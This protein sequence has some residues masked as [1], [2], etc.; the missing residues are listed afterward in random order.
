[1]WPGADEPRTCTATWATRRRRETYWSARSIKERAYGRD[2][3][4][5]AITLAN[6]GIAHSD[7]G[8]HA[9]R[10]DMLERAL[11]IEER[12]YGRDHMEVANTLE[13]RRRHA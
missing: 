4:Q 13:T 3:V 10:R 12:A 11:A 1:M 9:K 5:V 6:L 2:H 8:D 7:L